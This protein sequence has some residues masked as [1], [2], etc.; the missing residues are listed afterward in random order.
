V[1]SSMACR[2]APVGIGPDATLSRVCWQQHDTICATMVSW[3]TH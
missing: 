3:D 2:R 1:P